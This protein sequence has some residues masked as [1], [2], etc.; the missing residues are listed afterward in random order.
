MGMTTRTKEASWEVVADGV[1]VTVTHPD[2]VL[3]PQAG[4]TKRDLVE[5]YRAVS[6]RIMPHLLGRPMVL[7]RYPDG[8]AEEGFYQKRAPE[9]RPEWVAT[10]LLP[11]PTNDA[12]IE[13]VV[14]ENLATALWMVNIGAFEMNPW[15]AT[16]ADPE[17]PTHLVADLD[18]MG[19]KFKDVCRAALLVRDELQCR[20]YEPA[21]KTSGKSG[22]HV[23]APLTEKTTY[24]QVRLLLEEVGKA[25]DKEWPEVFAMEERIAEREGRIYFDYNQ[26]GYGSTI[27]AA[28]S[29]RP[30]PT[31]TVSM[32][33]SWKEVQK[34][35]DPR[36]YNVK[37]IG[38]LVD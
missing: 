31:A 14:V 36:S 32:P 19:G 35:P 37:S 25:L 1:I 34:A 21:V 38:Q 13:Y 4:V 11:S 20:G 17:H 24:P 27:T 10:A 8:V 3:F 7:H 16:A 9:H 33:L 22:L 29:V 30:T 2:K 6:D 12:P 18:P 5:Y 15:L 23:S 26:N 28:W